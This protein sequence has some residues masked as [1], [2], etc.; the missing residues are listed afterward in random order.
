MYLMDV[1]VY[2]DLHKT[3]CQL[4]P[5]Q[6]TSVLP[7]VHMLPKMDFEPAEEDYISPMYKQALRAGVLSTT[8]K[9]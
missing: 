2:Y 8:G 7:M 4:F 5:G 1:F 6:M 9:L 3:N